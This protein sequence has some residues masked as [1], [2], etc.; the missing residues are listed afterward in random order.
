M[1]LAV[2]FSLASNAAPHSIAVVENVRDA[3]AF[4]EW[5][6]RSA[7]YE[8]AIHAWEVAVRKGETKRSLLTII[9]YTLPTDQHR[10]WVID[11]D[12]SQLLFAERVAHG[13]NSGRNAMTSWSNVEGSKETSIG[14]A[15]TAE[16]Y[17]GKHGKSL[18]L[19]GL[20]TEFNNHNRQRAIVLHGASYVSDEFA[21]TYGRVGNSWGCPAVSDEVS[22]ALIDSIQGGS[23]IVGWFDDSTWL[24]KSSYLEH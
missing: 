9:D 8:D 2:L 20:E 11:I 22:G 23:L 3:S 6:L 5:G 1:I 18:R 17:W 16:I 12:E 21:K 19:D 15:L 24:E 10:L 13:K 4:E 7:V 14:V